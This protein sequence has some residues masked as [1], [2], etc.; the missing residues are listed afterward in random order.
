MWKSGTGNTNNLFFT[1]TIILKN[2]LYLGQ[3]VRLDRIV[4]AAKTPYAGRKTHFHLKLKEQLSI[5]KQ[6]CQ[7]LLISHDVQI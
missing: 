1:Y 7:V 4:Q 6:K 3:F 2:N 5:S